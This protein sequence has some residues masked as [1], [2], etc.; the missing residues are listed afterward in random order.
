MQG[1]TFYESITMLSAYKEKAFTDDNMDALNNLSGDLRNLEEIAK[2][3]DEHILLVSQCKNYF[4]RSI[5]K[6]DWK[7]E[8]L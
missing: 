7:Y 3:A 6:E 8:K 5:L 1:F 2:K 4:H